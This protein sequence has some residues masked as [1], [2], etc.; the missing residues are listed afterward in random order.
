MDNIRN[1]IIAVGDMTDEFTVHIEVV[2][3]FPA[4]LIAVQEETLAALQE[5][6]AVE[7]GCCPF[8]DWMFRLCRL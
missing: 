3:I 8:R 2:H 4:G 5:L 7:K 6:D 1:G